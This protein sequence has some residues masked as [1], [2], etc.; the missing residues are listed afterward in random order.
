[1]EQTPKNIAEEIKENLVSYIDLK[2]KIFKLSAYENIAQTTA[3]LT[4]GLIF[5][6]ISLFTILF[7]F[8]TLGLILGTYL[9]SFAGGFAIVSAL[10]LLILALIFINR[11]KLKELLIEK[12]LTILTANDQNNEQSDNNANQ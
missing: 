2:G 8:I 10:Y 5:L 1:M 6:T 12:I 11:K 7:I 3:I 9:N 4:Y